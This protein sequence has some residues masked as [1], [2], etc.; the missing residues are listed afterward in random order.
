MAESGSGKVELYDD[1][2]G[3]VEAIL[4]A[5]TAPPIV[6]G[7]GTFQLVGQ[8]LAD[9]DS[10]A[11]L[12]G[13]PGSMLF[14]ATNEAE[15]AIGL[16]T[17]TAMFDVGLMGTIVAECR[18]QQ[19]ALVTRQIFFGFSDVATD[20]AILE[21]AIVKGT[22]T[23]ITNTASDLCGFLLASELTDA[24]DWHGVY[25]G[26]TAAG[27][28]VS[29]GIDFGADAV[30]AT[31]QILRLEI[32]NNGTARWFV[33]GDLKQS[34]T[35]AASTTTDLIFNFLCEEKVTGNASMEVDYVKI[36]CNRDWTV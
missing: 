4:T 26:G 28:T 32:D 35:G 30:A 12:Q 9:T 20:L 17:A 2:T 3:G 13:P 1:F 23:T 24:A 29:T 31:W 18:L 11:V 19:A 15:H 10:G 34:V 6:I 16:Q 27:P 5:T 8:G 21:G 33:D 7:N 14:T 22:G 25:N 36:R